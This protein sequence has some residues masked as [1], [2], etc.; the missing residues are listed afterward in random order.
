[1]K[2][3]VRLTES[4]LIKLVKTVIQ[5]NEEKKEESLMRKIMRKLKGIND[6][7][8]KYNMDNDLPWDWK[9]TKEGYYE[10]IDGRKHHSGSN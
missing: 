2:K 5:E 10:K 7:Q 4:D 9:G 6:Q 8:L 1:M 3:I